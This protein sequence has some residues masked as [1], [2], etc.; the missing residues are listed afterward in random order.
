MPNSQE[1]FWEGSFGDEYSLRN[2]DLSHERS[3]FFREIAGLC[4]P[5]RSLCELG[6]NR[7]ENLRAIQL[8]GSG[9]SLTGIDINSSAVAIAR[10][11]IS[12]R[13][14]PGSTTTTVT[15][16]GASSRRKESLAASSANFDAA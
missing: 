16:N 6:A 11:S 3:E 4:G 8:S 5:I 14:A 12:V 9:A 13:T 1:H 7:G 2:S 15:P 10:P